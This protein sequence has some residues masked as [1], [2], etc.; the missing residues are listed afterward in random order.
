MNNAIFGK[1]LEN[2]RNH[3]DVRLLTRWDGRYDV[4]AMIAKPNFHSRSVFS[5]NLVAIDM[6]KLK[7]KFDKPIYVSMC[8]LDI[9]KTCLYE[10]HHE[11]PLYREKCEIMYTD[12]DSLIYHIECDDVYNIMKRDI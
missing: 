1:T 3:V 9:S 11:L 12:T 8:N 6:R 10:F 7:V 2:V 4:E 5:E